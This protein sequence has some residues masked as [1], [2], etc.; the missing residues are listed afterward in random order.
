MRRI[1]RFSF[2]IVKNFSSLL[3]R[4]VTIFIITVLT[5]S[6]ITRLLS[7]VEMGVYGLLVSLLYLIGLTA[8]FGLKKV[9]IRYIAGRKALGLDEEAKGIFWRITLISL[10]FIILVSIGIYLLLDYLKIFRLINDET[11]LSLY[12]IL[13]IL[14]SFRNTIQMGLQAQ[15]LFHYETLYYSIGY[16]LY[17]FLMV[18]LLLL[19]LGVRG[20]IIAWIIG[21]ILTIGLTLTKIFNIYKPF[22]IEGNDTGDIIKN[23]FPIYITDIILTSM[24]YGDRIASA[25]LGINV[26]AYFYI[27]TTGVMFLSALYQSVQESILPSLSEDYHLNGLDGINHSIK[28]IS[29]YVFIFI[30]PIFIIVAGLAEPLIFI[31]AGSLYISSAPILQI[32][33]IG[34][35][36][37]SFNY[38]LQ[39]AFIAAN[40]NE[41]LMV[42]I[43]VSIIIDLFIMI[44]LYPIIGALST[45]LGRTMLII[46]STLLMLII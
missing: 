4:Q 31:L 26:V 15:H 40:R 33:C 22:I 35:W 2:R 9:G 34:L 28:R 14:F 1:T 7:T 41:I 38:L 43:L 44:K 27:A 39:S 36:L 30:S 46:I 25:L 23:A 42:I 11:A 29:R 19:G 8:N 18:N 17:R 3:M 16:V 13:L 32:M 5:F 10:P 45:G 6:I 21:E 20:I 24:E 37:G 12:L